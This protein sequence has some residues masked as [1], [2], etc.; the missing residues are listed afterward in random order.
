MSGV[1]AVALLV[2]DALVMWVVL[3]LIDIDTL[4]SSLLAIV[5]VAL[6]VLD[7]AEIVVLSSTCGP[8]DEVL[9]SRL[10]VV[11][12]SLSEVVAV[13]LPSSEA[14]EV[15]GFNVISAVVSGTGTTDTV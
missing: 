6:V 7:R 8:D 11:V 5:T 10:R 4:V 9:S 1:E 15:L 2:V 3:S 12:F 14:E 13:M